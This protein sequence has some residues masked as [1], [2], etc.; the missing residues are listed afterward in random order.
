[1]PT[2]ITLTRWT[3]QGVEKVKESPARLDEFKKLVKSLG[4]EVKGFYMVTGRYDLVI[5]TEAPNDDVVAKVALVMASK[6]GVRSETLRAFT[7]D[8]FRKIIGGLP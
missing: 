8:E 6:G 2:Y 4:G 3:Q 1:M 5:V 7:E